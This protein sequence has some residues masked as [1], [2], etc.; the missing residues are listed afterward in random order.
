M[1]VE[2]SRAREIALSLPG[3]SETPHFH[4]T[5]FRTPRKMF[6]TMDLAGSDINLMFD[7]DL[8]DLFCE[9]APHAMAPVAGGWGR[10]GATRCD[11]RLI[12]EPT[13]SSALIAAHALAAPK[14]RSR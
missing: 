9:Q 11:L 1:A 10:M 3:V 2:P 12:D 14:L 8:R 4:R 13:L 5:S 7:P 6:A